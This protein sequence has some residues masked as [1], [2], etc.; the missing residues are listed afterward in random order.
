MSTPATIDTDLTQTKP[1]KTNLVQ[2]QMTLLLRRKETKRK[3][4]WG[5]HPQNPISETSASPI[6]PWCSVGVLVSEIYY[7]YS[8]VH[9]WCQQSDYDGY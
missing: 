2:K 7:K 1:L 8:I 6:T 3:I 9:D 5:L 4:V